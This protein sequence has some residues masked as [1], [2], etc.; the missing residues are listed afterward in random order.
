M[1]VIWG[2]MHGIALVINR[3]WKTLNRPL[4][5]VAGWLVTF[6]FVNFAWVFFRAKSLDDARR[7]LRGMLNLRSAAGVDAASVPVSDVAWGGW[8]S[9]YLLR[10]VPGMVGLVPSYL[11]I[12][13]AFV[14]IARKN[15][16]ELLRSSSGSGAPVYAG[17]LFSVA[18]CFTLATAST[19]F[20][21]FNF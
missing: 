21:Y 10:F 19:V 18:M 1:Y 4:H 3:L 8:L 17:V 12:M 20:L 2:A 5:P 9:D 7:V 14:L 16:M 6:V 11:A 13:S 15:S